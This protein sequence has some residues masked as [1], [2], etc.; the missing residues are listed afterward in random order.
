MVANSSASTHNG[1][2]SPATAELAIESVPFVSIPTN[3]TEPPES[4][5][6]G[7]DNAPADAGIRAAALSIRG[8]ALSYSTCRP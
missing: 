6:E 8:Q 7:F 3:A 1:P 4:D 2:L 5:K